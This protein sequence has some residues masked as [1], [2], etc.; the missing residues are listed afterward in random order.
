MSCFFRKQSSPEPDYVRLK[1]ST[2]M[3]FKEDRMSSISS[4][5]RSRSTEEAR[6][7]R[8]EYQ[9][10]EAEQAKK[11]KKEIRKLTQQF[12]TKVQE[13]KDHFG[14]QVDSMKE[15]SAEN[16]GR[17]D[18]KYNQDIENIRNMYTETL[19]KKAEDSE[20]RQ[21]SGEGVVDAEIKKERIINEQ[22]KKLTR[23]QYESAVKQQ[24]RK[25][26]EFAEDMR[27]S[28]RSNLQKQWQKLNEKHD[29]ELRSIADDRD[30]R[31]ASL[32]SEKDESVKALDTQLRDQKRSAD[33]KLDQVNK[34]WM[35]T[36]VSSQSENDA[37]VTARDQMLQSEKINL[38][39]KYAEQL[40]N[41]LKQ[42]DGFQEKLKEQSVNYMEKRI[43]SAELKEKQARHE[44][45]T[46]QVKARRL[47][48][49]ELNN[50]RRAY[51][52]RFKDLN[53]QKE[54]IS[55]VV[56]EKAR[57]RINDVLDR[58]EKLFSDQTRRHK[59]DQNIL[60][61]RNLQ[62]RN[63]L[64]SNYEGEIEFLKNKTEDRIDKMLTNSTQQQ[65]RQEK[66]YKKDVDNLK[67]IHAER[68]MDQR[69]AQ[70]DMIKD[71]YLRMEK[72]L[73][74]QE[75]K[76][77]ERFNYT[78]AEH[79]S[80]V[81]ALHDDYKTQLRRQEEGFQKKIE[82]RDKATSQ[83]YE[84]QEMKFKNRMAQLKEAHDQ[85]LARIEKKHQQQMTALASR[86]GSISKKA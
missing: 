37:I 40:A 82:A 50:I 39:R 26:A 63:Q 38:K 62:D 64:V 54:D 79:T 21:K 56:N 55:L 25:F 77:E 10:R 57:G 1:G 47:T 17:R 27:K 53:R 76:N 3:F 60:L 75:K 15:K 69:V 72:K 68:L 30:K 5:D 58:S 86:I 49:L 23:N 66:L 32:T 28:N 24:E 6:N 14:K 29:K 44:Y 8:E 18:E 71:Q 59:L 45:D 13:L 81:Q 12:E 73:R 51:N 83:D 16:F 20:A 65:V 78:V 33:K 41:K 48:D 42:M 11:H 61:T 35:V 67:N 85:D 80:Q 4:S 22:Q 46:N 52:E 70:I 84:A 74:D 43:R 19:R 7:N 31:I 9:K 34:N 36:Y 2:L